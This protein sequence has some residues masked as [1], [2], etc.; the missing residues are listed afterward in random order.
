MKL[1]RISWQ[2][3]FEIMALLAV[4]S[5]FMSCGSERQVENGANATAEYYR[6][7]EFPTGRQTLTD[8]STYNIIE[9]SYQ[10]SADSV[11]Q[12]AERAAMRLYDLSVIEE[13]GIQRRTR[14]SPIIDSSMQQI[15]IGKIDKAVRA[16]A[17]A[18]QT[19]KDKIV[20]KLAQ[21]KGMT[22][23]IVIRSVVVPVSRVLHPPHV[24]ELM[25][26]GKYER[27]ILTR[28]DDDLEGKIKK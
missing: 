14:Q 4:S 15:E 22:K 13:D 7:E 27:W 16:N 25:S 28:I 8:V 26:N 1:N 11:W 20:I 12:A 3:I 6:V 17:I 23:V 21:D 9:L 18:T 24:M 19:W 5:C 2:G 10:T